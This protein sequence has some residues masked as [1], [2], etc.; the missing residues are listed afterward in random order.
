MTHAERQTLE[1]L[2]ENLGGFRHTLRAFKDK[3]VAR[4]PA[5]DAKA[6]ISEAIEELDDVLTDQLGRLELRDV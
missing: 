1:A 2:I 5:G 4:L 3:N 6:V